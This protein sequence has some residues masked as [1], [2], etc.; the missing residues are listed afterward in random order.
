MIMKTYILTAATAL[1][2]L[3]LSSCSKLD[4]KLE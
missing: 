4:P 2:L 1:G 3:A